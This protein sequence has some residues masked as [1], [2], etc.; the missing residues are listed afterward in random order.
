MKPA[1]ME[2]YLKRYRAQMGLVPTERCAVLQLSWDTDA[3]PRFAV[4]PFEFPTCIRLDTDKAELTGYTN[5]CG[6]GTRKD[7]KI[8]FTYSADIAPE[9]KLCVKC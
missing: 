5:A 1:C 9:L 8:Y 2:L 6:D 4:L 3:T 7:F